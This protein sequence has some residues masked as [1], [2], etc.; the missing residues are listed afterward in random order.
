MSL[1]HEIVLFGVSETVHDKKSPTMNWLSDLVS[2][3]GDEVPTAK[4]G[5]EGFPSCVLNLTNQISS[6]FVIV[7]SAS[8][9]RVFKRIVF[10]F[11]EIAAVTLHMLLP[12]P[13]Q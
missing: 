13:V 3:W 2:I 11:P 1:F 9:A 6:S 7:I 10:K 12:G 8:I 5:G 4:L